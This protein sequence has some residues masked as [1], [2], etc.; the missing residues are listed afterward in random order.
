M[1]NIDAYDFNAAAELLAAITLIDA[2]PE[3]SKTQMFWQRLSAL[4]EPE[5]FNTLQSNN[6][7]SHG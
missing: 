2:I 1:N 6:R 4:C 7:M 5:L 3:H